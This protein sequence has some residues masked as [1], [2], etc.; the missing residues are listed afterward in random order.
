MLAGSHN[1]L[2]WHRHLRPNEYLL[3]V[4]FQSKL[5]VCYVPDIPSDLTI[6]R[7]SSNTSRIALK[8]SCAS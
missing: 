5:A 3:Y 4:Y 6:Q 8:V 1:M 7:C 2:A